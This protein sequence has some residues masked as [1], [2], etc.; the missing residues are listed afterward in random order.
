[1]AREGSGRAEEQKERE[2]PTLGQG[3]VVGLVETLEQ[4]DDGLSVNHSGVEP[5]SVWIPS[6]AG[7]KPE[8]PQV[9]HAPLPLDVGKLRDSVGGPSLE[10]G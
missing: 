1:M 4:S 10:Q 9:R 2:L 5:N 3:A 8:P 6:P 7:W